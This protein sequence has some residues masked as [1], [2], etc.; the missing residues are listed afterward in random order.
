M[1]IPRVLHTAL[2][3]F[4]IISTRHDCYDYIDQ[5][6]NQFENIRTSYQTFTASNTK[7]ANET[8]FLTF[9][10]GR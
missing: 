8:T 7:L 9:L 6:R 5:M 1:R 10:L 4:I 3:S 2:K